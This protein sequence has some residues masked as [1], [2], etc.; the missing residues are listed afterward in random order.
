MVMAA[1]RKLAQGARLARLRSLISSFR[2]NKRGNVA[3]ITALA[4]LPLMAAVGCVIDYTTASMIKTKLQAAADAATLASVS[5]NSSVISTAKAMSGNGTVSGG[6]TFVTNFFNANLSSAPETT[7][8][9]G[10]TPTATV[11]RTSL[12]VTSTMSFTAQVPTFFMG[13][14]GYHNIALSGTSTATYTLPTYIDFYLMLDVSGSMSF[15]STTAEQS[16]LLAVNP[17]NL[18]GSNGYPGGC[19]F[20]CHFT[21]Q[22]TCGQ[23][24]SSNP[25]QGPI[26]AAGSTTNPGSGGYCQGFIISRLGTTP[27]SFASGTYNPTNGNSVNW[28]NTQV[29]SCPTAGTTSCIQ[30]RADAVGYAVSDLLTYANTKEVVTN[31]FRVGLYPFIRYLYSYFPLTTDITSTGSGTLNYAATQLATLLDT[32]VNSNLGSGGTHF[33]NAFPSMNTLISS[34]GTGASSSSTLP[35]VF[36]VTD[37]SQDC[38]YQS[39]GSW[40]GNPGCT[41]HYNSA[42]TIDT[43]LCTTLKNRG[44]TISVLYIPYETIQNP[45]TFAGSEDIYAND[46]IPNIPGALQSCASSGFYFTANTPADIDAALKKMFDKAVS[47]AHISN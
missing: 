40:G 38:Q 19:T 21:R 14:M 16:R 20:A 31:Q 17:D 5:L 1:M 41:P 32:G 45:T 15:P 13:I 46:N 7:G 2:L 44:I 18:R 9:T 27:V 33:E 6:S 35:Y 29:T 12:T 47:T 10:L 11:T 24:S 34:V 37:G 22:G 36:L 8:Y 42:T 28:T 25:Y 23:T 3:V 39:G 4:A 43:S 30:L 26:P